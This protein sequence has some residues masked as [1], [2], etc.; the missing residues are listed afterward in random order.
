MTCYAWVPIL[1]IAIIVIGMVIYFNNQANTQE[2]FFSYHGVIVSWT[3][4]SNATATTSYQWFAC[5]QTAAPSCGPTACTTSSSSTSSTCPITPNPTATLNEQT[6]TGLDFG[7]SIAFSVR[8][9]DTV[10]NL[11]S[12]WVTTVINTNNPARTTGSLTITSS[13][14]STSSTINNPPA[15]NDIILHL[16]AIVKPN[17]GGLPGTVPNGT[18]QITR[19][20]NVW[21]YNAGGIAIDID[22]SNN[23]QTVYT[24]DA[25]TTSVQ[26]VW[27]SNGNVQ[28]PG[29]LQV[30]DVVAFYILA[31]SNT[32]QQLTGNLAF[33]GQTNVT[34]ATPAPV[35]PGAPTGVTYTFN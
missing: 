31:T 9:I 32:T 15:P 6:T 20:T 35:A 29:P 12:D 24:I 22:N 7:Q 21:T 23:T 1:L 34:V 26:S 5:N 16:K 13:P 17:I 28:V 2:P 8:S 19:G 4:P 3:P 10:S 18:I 33:Y 30:G 11:T 25:D 27:Q 14:S